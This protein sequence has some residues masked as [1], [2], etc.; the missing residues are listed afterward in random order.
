MTIIG[1]EVPVAT[2]FA[3]RL[4]GLALL[5]P[6]RAPRGLLIPRCSGVHTFGMRFDLDL[7]FLDE[8][9]RVVELSRSVG[10]RR[11]ERCAAARQVLEL[12]SP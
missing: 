7:L 2:T 1:V 9:G 12:R 3:S 10:P 6:D 4:L 8:S 11:I 5:D